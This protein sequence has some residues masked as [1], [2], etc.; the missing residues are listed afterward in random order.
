[1]LAKADEMNF[2]SLIKPIIDIKPD[3]PIDNKIDIQPDIKP[4]IKKTKK[5]TIPKEKQKVIQPAI[6]PQSPMDALIASKKKGESKVFVGLH[7]TEDVDRVLTQFKK[8][9]DIDRSEAV[10]N[11]V[12]LFL[13]DYFDK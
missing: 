10:T 1:V 13:K 4:V 6:E 12:R 5:Q 9:T 2:N 3:I 8:D 11:A 7:L